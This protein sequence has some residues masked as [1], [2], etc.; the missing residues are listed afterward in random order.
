MLEPVLASPCRALFWGVVSGCPPAL[1][2][3]RGGGPPRLAPDI[4]SSSLRFQCRVGKLRAA[5]APWFFASS[6]ARRGAH[7]FCGRGAGPA[8]LRAVAGLLLGRLWG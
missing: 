2:G 1:V 8:E 6:A 3:A 5:L 7:A 4:R